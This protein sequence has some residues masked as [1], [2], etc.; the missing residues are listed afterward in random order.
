MHVRNCVS[1]CPAKGMHCLA[2]RDKLDTSKEIF[3]P[4]EF[5]FGV[6]SIVCS[7]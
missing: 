1:V 6:Q 2:E 3:P 4:L 5:Q 7:K